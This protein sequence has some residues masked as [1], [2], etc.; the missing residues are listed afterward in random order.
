MSRN[1]LHFARVV[2]GAPALRRLLVT[3]VAVTSVALGPG[4][5]ADIASG[6][7]TLSAETDYRIA[8]AI[9]SSSGEVGAIQFDVFY[10][11]EG[12]QFSPTFNGTRGACHVALTNAFGVSNVR[13]DGR[14]TIG[15]AGVPGFVTP[16]QVASCK[17]SAAEA[18]APGDFDIRVVDAIDSKGAFMQAQPE[19]RVTAVTV[20]DG[21]AEDVGGL[22]S[23]AERPAATNERR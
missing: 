20:D 3:A 21:A 15:V 4:V 19:M 23:T 2:A 6:Q 11:G 1:L 7:S 16:T 22:A 14:I 18:I 13:E 5:S 10:K 8:L 9:V 17:F 12:G